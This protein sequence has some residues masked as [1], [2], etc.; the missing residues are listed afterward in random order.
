[1]RIYALALLAVFA[2]ALFADER[3]Y[4][5]SAE[6][7]AGFDSLAKR[8]PDWLRIEELPGGV[9]GLYAA[10]LTHHKDPVR[11]PAIVVLGS[12]R[13]DELSPGFAC[14]ELARAML[15]RANDEAPVRFGAWLQAVEIIFVPTPCAAS[16]DLMLGANPTAVPG[17]LTPLDDD[18]DNQT[19]EDG[20]EDI[21]GDGV[22]SQLRV[23]RAGGRFRPSPRDSRILIESAPG[24]EGEFDLQWEGLDNDSDGEINEDPR[25]SVTLANDFAIRWSDKQA[26]ANRF[27]MLTAQSRALAE[28]FVAHPN[29]SLAINL[30]SLGERLTVASGPPAVAGPAAGRGRRDAA[31]SE[32]VLARDKQMSDALLKLFREET[33]AKIGERDEPE[34]EGLG[35]VADW[36]HEACGVYALNYYLARVPSPEKEGKQPPEETPPGR[37]EAAQLLWMSHTP[38]QHQAWKAF[39]H[40][41]LGEA[42]I[43]GWLITARRDATRETAEQ[44]A[45]K[46]LDFL[47]A[48]CSRVASLRVTKVEAKDLGAD[49]YKIRLTLS[50]PGALDYK[51]GFAQTNRIGQPIFVALGDDKEIEL[52]SGSRRQSVE[53]LIGG[54]TVTF[55]W[56]VRTKDPWRFMKFSIE[57]E[58]AMPVEESKSVKGCEEWKE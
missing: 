16:M 36:L 19:D 52:V 50:N 10:R 6:I 11:R 51:P 15:V 14:L 20:P 40:P 43:G 44:A 37:D 35:N 9:S 57:G 4:L 42:E 21:N 49:S 13:G 17:L 56:V 58:R 2:T 24:E 46:A 54:A 29:I 55:E 27:P 30:R 39:K 38:E 23:K 22:I 12:L 1:M 5:S 7:R 48:L 25:G 33:G 32:T 47:W 3:K 31:T 26:G 28:F 41:Q 45:T 18:R 8:E 53:N 34:G